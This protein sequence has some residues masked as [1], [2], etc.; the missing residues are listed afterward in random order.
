MEKLS[1]RHLTF[2]SSEI[3]E[4]KLLAMRVLK[5]VESDKWSY[6]DDWIKDSCLL[7]KYE[8]SSKAAMMRL[9]MGSTMK[10]WLT[11]FLH[12]KITNQK[13]KILDGRYSLYGPFF[14]DNLKIELLC[15]LNTPEKELNIYDECS[16]PG[17]VSLVLGAGNMNFLSIIDVFERVFIHKECVFLKHHPFRP[18]LYEPYSIILEPLISENIVHMVY[19]TSPKSEL[20]KNPHVSH[21]HFTGSENT[22]K[23]ITK[24]L[25]SETNVTAELG[26]ATP[27]IIMPGYWTDKE[28][29]NAV[30]QIVIAKISGG[31]SYC[32]SAQ[33]ILIPQHWKQKEIFCISLNEELQKQ[34]PEPAYY[35][36]S[37]K[38]KNEIVENCFEFLE[39]FD[40]SITS[41][42]SIMKR[43]SEKNNDVVLIDCGILN[44]DSSFNNYCFDKEVFC[45]VLVKGEIDYEEGNTD[46]YLERV[47]D[48]ANKE[49]HGSLSCSVLFPDSLHSEYIIEK[50]IK[51][52]DYGTIAIN[53]WSVIGYMAA[54]VGGTWGAHYSDRKSGRGRIG[55]IYKIKYVSKTIIR[56]QKLEN[57]TNFT[58]PL[59]PK[60]IINLIYLLTVKC[61]TF[62][63]KCVALFKFIF[64]KSYRCDLDN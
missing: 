37:I 25:S 41:Y 38:R 44:G 5:S 10:K 12:G 47:C 20:I 50:C 42:P 49:L 14:C 55:N 26:C 3:R 29:K 51:L 11:T 13:L 4:R 61:S 33:V 60:I 58:R 56:G 54:L 7:E 48:F 28:I 32:M 36:G 39:N 59:P 17:T 46:D 9:I 35:P 18:F 16:K 63:K 19:D 8:N 64:F 22:Y 62:F 30:K 40:N 34:K 2:S 6:V 15:D 24:E 27:W 43:T 1:K 57:E 45:P 23:A 52:L 21:I 53:I 31:G